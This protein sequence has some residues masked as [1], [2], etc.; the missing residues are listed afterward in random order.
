VQKQLEAFRAGTGPN[1]F[2][3]MERPGGRRGADGAPG[4]RPPR[5]AVGTRAAC[6]DRA[7][8]EGRRGG[9]GGGPGGPGGGFGGGGRGGGGGRLNFELYHTWHL[10]D[11]VTIAD[12]GPTLDLLRGDTLGSGGGQ[13]RHELELQAGYSNNGL[14]A[15]LSGNWMSATQVDGGTLAAPET[16]NFG[17]L[18]TLNLRL[19]ADLGQRREWVKDHP[20]LRGMRV[21]LSV[22][23]I[24]NSRQRVT[25]ASGVTPVAYAPDYIDPLGRT[26]RLSVRKLF[27]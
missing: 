18:A 2:E 17:A 10:T 4:D 24:A 7:P 12:G 25:D 26:I 5:D 27:F 8:G 13:S 6:G 19:F 20:W 23:N 22:D 3:G 1:P 11:R 9:F 15:R 16:L 21:T 14:G